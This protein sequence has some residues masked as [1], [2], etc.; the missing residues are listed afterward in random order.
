VRYA[1][2]IILLFLFLSGA[3]QA[4]KSSVSSVEHS[5]EKEIFHFLSGAAKI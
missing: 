2:I 3:A 4:Q 1:G 5:F